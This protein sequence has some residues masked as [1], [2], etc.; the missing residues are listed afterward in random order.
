MAVTTVNVTGNYPLDGSGGQATGQI[1]FTLSAPLQDPVAKKKYPVVTYPVQLV[2]GAFSISLVANNDPTTLPAGLTYWVVERIVG[3]LANKFQIVIPYNG[4]AT[5]DMSSLSPVTN[6]TNSFVGAT[7]AT[8]PPGATGA[9][10]GVGP[11]GAAGTAIAIQ[12][13][14]V[15]LTS[16]SIINFIGAGVTATDNV[17][18][19]RTDVNI[20]GGGGG[21]TGLSPVATKTAAYTANAGE[22]VPC[23]T[24]TTPFTVTLPALPAVGAIVGVYKNDSSVNTLTIVASG[25]GT[26]SGDATTTTSTRNGGATFEHL[27]SNAWQIV[28]SYLTTGSVGPPGPPGAGGP[29]GPT[30]TTTKGDVAGF[31]T[32]SARIP[33]GTDGTV[34]TADSTNALGVSYKAPAAGGAASVGAAIKPA[35]SGASGVGWGIPAGS[36][37]SLRAGFLAAATT[38]CDIVYFG[39]ST[40]FGSGGF[41]GPPRKIRDLLTITAGLTDGGRG[42][43]NPNDTAVSS[44]ENLAPVLSRAGFNLAAQAYDPLATDTYASTTANDVVTFQGKGTAVRIHAGRTG[45]GSGRY[46]YSIDGGAAVI[47]DGAGTVTADVQTIY[48][49]GLAEGTHTLAITN[50]ANSVVPP[51]NGGG[52]FWNGASAGGTGGTVPVGNYEIVATGITPSGET[53]ASIISSAFALT[54]GQNINLSA[55]CR[56]SNAAGV[57][58]IRFFARFNGAGAF[59]FIGS[60]PIAASNAFTSFTW[61][62]SPAL[63]A[64]TNP[65]SVS[66]AGLYGTTARC[67]VTVDF[68]RAVGVVV[69]KQSVSGIATATF[70]DPTKSANSAFANANSLAALGMQQFSTTTSPNGSDWGLSAAAKPTTRRPRAA[71]FALGINDQQPVTTEAL[72]TTSVLSMVEGFGLFVRMCRQIGCDPIMV[73]PHYIFSSGANLYSSRF[74]QAAVAAA[75]AHGCAWVDYNTALGPVGVNVSV[76]PHIS[77]TGYDIE[78]QFIYDKLLSQVL[79]GV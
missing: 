33:V 52:A 74:R 64:G 65:P 56:N 17:G 20:P 31:S 48:V 75:V 55:D 3:A 5:Q 26:T 45:G 22:L 62:G 13:E 72:A 38:P 69:H 40:G 15:V 77:Q 68:V 60:T 19:T 1:E 32:V 73:V 70:F 24:T 67:A 39:D 49:G 9:T 41:G 51:P 12:D 25:S 21:T 23:N 57:T 11:P 76:G 63:A 16:R 18:A 35:G 34:L 10:G 14:G 54:A 37:E 8:G 71:I 79:P 6:S 58:T 27:G 44:G 43:A 59:G 78:G 30:P 4:G 66:T 28:A 42:V 46:T 53:A 29:A 50:L 7:G 61:T 47:V 36:L 2:A